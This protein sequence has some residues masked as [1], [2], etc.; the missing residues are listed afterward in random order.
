MP[1][2]GLT[3][4]ERL[5]AG[6]MGIVFRAYD[7]QRGVDV[8]LKWLPRADGVALS[9]F[10]QEFRALADL[11]HPNLLP[12]Y[13]LHCVAGTWFFTMPLIDATSF[14]GW[15]RPG[16]DDE[17]DAPGGDAT[18]TSDGW[19]A[20][21]VTSSDPRAHVAPPRSARI[22]TGYST[23]CKATTQSSPTLRSWLS[24]RPEMRARRISATRFIAA[25]AA[26]TRLS[27]GSGSATPL[28]PSGNSSAMKAVVMAPETKRGWSITAE[29]NGRLWPMPSTSNV[30]SARRISSIA[31]A[32]S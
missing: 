9:R 15:V 28:N 25:A 2:P 7:E 32:R 13:E 27:I 14:L 20:T 6:S 19:V 29:Q 3:L 5:G 22:A 21:T 24:I 30:S 11:L 12:L 16:G 4:R 23:P 26:A 17:V 31:A 18:G 8:A 10:K 1:L